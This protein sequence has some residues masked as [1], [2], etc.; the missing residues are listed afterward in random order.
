VQP[1]I[2]MA[3]CRQLLLE[4][5]PD[6]YQ[7]LLEAGVG[8]ASLSTQMPPSLPDTAARPGDEQLTMVMTRRS[9]L[10]WVFQRAILAERGATLGSGVRVLG[11]LSRAGTPPHVT[12]LHTSEG[13]VA[14]DLVIDAAGRR[15]PIDRWLKNI[16]AHPTATWQA[17]CGVAYF[18]RHYRVRDG[19]A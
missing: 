18:S 6:V 8:E 5:L 19:A 11:F 9:T 2:V 17:E 14:A 3:R 15:S 10:D 7:Q 4:Y 12:G 13:D 1:H 16:G